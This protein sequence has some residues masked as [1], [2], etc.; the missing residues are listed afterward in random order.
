ML[1]LFHQVKSSARLD[2]MKTNSNEVVSTA[3]SSQSSSGGDSDPY[4]NSADIMPLK[5][6]HLDRK[7]SATARLPKR[8]T[9]VESPT[10]KSAHPSDA[11]RSERSQEMGVMQQPMQRPSVVQ[12]TGRSPPAQHTAIAQQSYHKGPSNIDTSQQGQVL[13]PPFARGNTE[14]MIVDESGPNSPAIGSD[15]AHDMGMPDEESI[16]LAD[17]PQI[18][19]AA[20]AREQRRSLPRQSSVPYI[21]ELSAL[22]LAI[23]K[24]CAVLILHRS[25]LKDHFDLDEILELVEVKK[26]G[27]WNKLFKGGNDKKNV[28]KKGVSV[29]LVVRLLA[30]NAFR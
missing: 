29:L 9:I 18:M 6:V 17:L 21:A 24:H 4:R 30:F 16:T 28:K 7:L 1:S 20:Q 19:E 25:P 5:S 15:E 8:S 26:G 23:V 3:G 12:P 11:M 13:R 14:V 27:F 10:G 2:E 22:E